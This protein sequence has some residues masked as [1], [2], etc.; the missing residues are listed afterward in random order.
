MSK[1]QNSPPVVGSSLPG[2]GTSLPGLGTSLLGARNKWPPPEITYA[3]HVIY[4]FTAG[5]LPCPAGS[6]L[7]TYLSDALK[8]D[9]ERITKILEPEPVRAFVACKGGAALAKRDRDIALLERYKADFQ[10]QVLDGGLNHLDPVVAPLPPPVASNP[11]VLQFATRGASGYNTASIFSLRALPTSGTYVVTTPQAPPSPSF[12]S[13]LANDMALLERLR[14][15]MC[16]D[17]KGTGK[18]LSG[19]TVSGG[20]VVSVAWEHRGLTG[21]IPAAAGSS[22]ADL[23]ALTHLY[24]SNNELQGP[25]PPSLPLGLKTLSLAHNRGLE[26]TVPAS[27]AALT[28]LQHLYMHNTGI[29]GAPC[30]LYDFVDVQDFLGNLEANKYMALRP[31]LS[32]KQPGRAK[33]RE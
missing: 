31:A 3:T 7:G 24:L 33:V 25:L 17:S 19:V 16:R 10:A 29:L 8:C 2:V 18:L 11:P 21:T 9:A 4:M 30:P 15:E 27:Y 12:S 20:R 23:T 14:L 32:E 28:S 26:G 22:F 5:I 6:D 13:K 1:Q